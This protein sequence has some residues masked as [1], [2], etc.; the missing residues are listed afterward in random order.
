MFTPIYK[1]RIG[2]SYGEFYHNKNESI[3][4]GKALA[5][6]SDLEKC[7]QWS[8]AALTEVAANIFKDKYPENS[9]LVD[10]E[11]PVMLASEIAN[12]KYSVVNWTLANHPV[13]QEKHNWMYREEDNSKVQSY[14]NKDVEQ[15]ILNS[16]AFHTNICSQCK[17]PRNRA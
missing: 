5:E 1:F 15:K 10:Y 7:Q 4:I 14:S 6:A 9:I 2:I 17:E 3:Y 11:V 13:I 8:G 16:E 12:R